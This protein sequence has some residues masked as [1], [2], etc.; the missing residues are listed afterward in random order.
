MPSK[1][2]TVSHTRRTR[3]M[4]DNLQATLGKTQTLGALF[5]WPENEKR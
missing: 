2:E 1:D 5:F 4:E 3:A